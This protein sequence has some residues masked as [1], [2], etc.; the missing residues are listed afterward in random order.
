[1]KKQAAPTPAKRENMMRYFWLGFFSIWDFS[2]DMIYSAYPKV[3]P[4]SMRETFALSSSLIRKSM[5]EAFFKLKHR[6]GQA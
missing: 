1:M 3:K 4:L 6:Y 2:G 5:Q